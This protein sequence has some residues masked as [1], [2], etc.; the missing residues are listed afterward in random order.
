M[1]VK[2]LVVPALPAVHSPIEQDP[3]LRSPSSALSSPRHHGAK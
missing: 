3:A 1:E 2:E